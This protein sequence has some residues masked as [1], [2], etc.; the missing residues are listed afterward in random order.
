[1][2]GESRLSHSANMT[3]CN[4]V[5]TGVQLIDNAALDL[6][7]QQNDSVIYIHVPILFHIFSP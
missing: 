7:A 4:L 3:C 6:G 2:L 5:Y 1:M